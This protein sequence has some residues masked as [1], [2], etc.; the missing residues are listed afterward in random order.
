M[1]G[2]KRFFIKWAGIAGA[3]GA[4]VLALNPDAFSH[5][6]PVWTAIGLM[7]L[8]PAYIWTSMVQ[9]GKAAQDAE[10]LQHQRKTMAERA[11][12]IILRGS[13]KHPLL[14][15]AAAGGS[16]EV[17]MNRLHLLLGASGSVIRS[18]STEKVPAPSAWTHVRRAIVDAHRQWLVAL[19]A[20]YGRVD[21]VWLDVSKLAELLLAPTLDEPA[22]TALTDQIDIQFNALAVSAPA[23]Q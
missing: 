8:L 5:P 11:H 20:E 12:R 17:I 13:W 16:T 14:S 10:R 1:N 7:A 9:M 2:V 3:G 19:A 21:N 4:I 15:K 6:G 22:I 18:L 23:A